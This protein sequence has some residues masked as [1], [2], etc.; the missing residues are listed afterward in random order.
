MRTCHTGEGERNA[1]NGSFT[2][3]YQAAVLIGVTLFEELA[4]W[5]K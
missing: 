4:N 2:C 5:S 1:I 3:V